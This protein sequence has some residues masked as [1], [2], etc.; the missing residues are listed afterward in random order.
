MLSLRGLTT[1]SPVVRHLPGRSRYSLG[2]RPMSSSSIFTES[3]ITGPQSTQF[4]TRTYTPANTPR[5]A[6]VFI[7]GFAEH[8]GRYTH[9]HPL[10]REHDIA[11][12]ALDL[13]GFGKTALDT[14]GHKNK[15]SAYGKTSWA[16]QMADIAWAVEHVKKTFSEVPIFL[17]GHSMGGAQAL[18]FVTHAEKNNHSANVLS[19]AGVIATSPLILQTKPAPKLLRW[20]GGKASTLLPHKLVSADVIPDDLSHDVAVNNAYMKDPLVK[21]FGS[22]R[23]LHDML[24]NGEALLA[25]HYKNW[26]K[27]LPLFLAHGTEDKVTSWKASQT[28]YEKI[29]ALDKRIKLFEGGFHELQNE[30]DGVKEQLVADVIA[31]IEAHL[32]VN[33]KALEPKEQRAKM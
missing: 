21:H 9:F 32:Q 17:M 13:R 19:L 33:S 22:L 24:S 30:P 8:V 12:F 1:A 7:H 2:F 4:Y 29:P 11:V 5:A 20:V 23:G 18:G 15:D 26:P 10:L 31:F 16:E 6:I 3:W 28:F 25:T 27:S 14:E